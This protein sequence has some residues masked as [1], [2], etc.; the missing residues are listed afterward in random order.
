MLPEVNDE[1]KEEG[2]AEEESDP[3]LDV[4]VYANITP[5]GS[6]EPLNF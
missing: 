5:D 1:D 6:P 3:E 2:A 4:R